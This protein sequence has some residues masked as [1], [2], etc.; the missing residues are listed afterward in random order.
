MIGGIMENKKKFIYICENGHYSE[1]KICPHCKKK[2]IKFIEY[3]EGDCVYC[4]NLC[5]GYAYAAP[6]Q[7]L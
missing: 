6:I 2:F 5:P 3:M 1:Q 4:G 7:I